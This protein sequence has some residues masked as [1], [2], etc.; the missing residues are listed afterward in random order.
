MDAY[1]NWAYTHRLHGQPVLL[2]E[3]EQLDEYTL[4]RLLTSCVP[5]A[6][7]QVCSVCE[8][9]LILNLTYQ[10]HGANTGSAK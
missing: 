4:T 7:A 10:K 6:K 8:W 3:M 2:E 5:A 1:E 9:L